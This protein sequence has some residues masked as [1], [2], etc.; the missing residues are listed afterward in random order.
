MQRNLMS[1]SIQQSS[2]IAASGKVT[3]KRKDGH[4]FLL[5]PSYDGRITSGSI[6][7]TSQDNVCS[8]VK[9]MVKDSEK[10]SDLTSTTHTQIG[11]G[12][13]SGAS[14]TS[15]RSL[16]LYKIYSALFGRTKKKSKKNDEFKKYKKSILA[17]RTFLLRLQ[18][19]IISSRNNA[20]KL[21]KEIKL[22]KENNEK[23]IEKIYVANYEKKLEILKANY[24][25]QISDNI[26]TK[27]Q[28]LEQLEDEARESG[29]AT[30]KE[31]MTNEIAVFTENEKTIENNFKKQKATAW[32]QRSMTKEE[33]VRKQIEEINTKLNEGLKN[34][35]KQ[36]T[37]QQKDLL[38]QLAEKYSSMMSIQKKIEALKYKFSIREDLNKE[39]L[40]LWTAIEREIEVR[41]HND[42]FDRRIENYNTRLEGGDWENASE[43]G[44]FDCG[45]DAFPYVRS[46]N[47][48]SEDASSQWYVTLM[49]GDGKRVRGGINSN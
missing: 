43:D 37:K 19:R 9:E 27:I 44:T 38:D 45:S 12:M 13:R 36:Q 16:F 3:D 28:R 11:C 35:M 17:Q 34:Q 49:F 48:V 5:V 29:V 42:T 4:S 24:N 18:S 8:V 26:K 33:G 14:V 32:A 15:G 30:P 6:H 25:Q 10:Q 31:E 46:A 39:E 41:N 1:A 7:L 23:K 22:E 21:S 20:S 2:W 47:G 40:S